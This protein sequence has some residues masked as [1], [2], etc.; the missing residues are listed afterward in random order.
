MSKDSMVNA[1]NVNIVKNVNNVNKVIYVN[2]VNNVL[3]I[4]NV[5]KDSDFQI[6]KRAEVAH[7]LRLI[8][9]IVSAFFCSS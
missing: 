7:H 4:N 6:V 9:G 8:F 2:N 3:N 5:N 1:S